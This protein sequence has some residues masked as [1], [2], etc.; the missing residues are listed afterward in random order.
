[1]VLTILVFYFARKKLWL[2]AGLVGV[3]AAMTKLIGVIIFI[4][5]LI[6]YLLVK[7]EEI[8]EKWWTGID[9]KIVYCFLPGLG[10]LMYFTYLWKLTGSF[11]CIFLS[12][13]I[14]GKRTILISYIY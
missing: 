12:R 11:F 10:T 5:L 8:G 4:P 1:M 7:K 2:Y 3:L 14:M 6:E 9:F 13:A